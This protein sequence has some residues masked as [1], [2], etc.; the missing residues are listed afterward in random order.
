MPL[1]SKI[2]EIAA[3]TANRAVKQVSADLEPIVI[4]ERS[5]Q[6]RKTGK[7]YHRNMVLPGFQPSFIPQDTPR[8]PTWY[9]GFFNYLSDLVGFRSNIPL[10][11]LDIQRNSPYT[12]KN[13]VIIGVHGWFPGNIIRRVIG[14]PVGTSSKFAAMMGLATIQV[15]KERFG[16]HIPHHAITMISLDGEGKVADRLELLYSQ[17][18]DPSKN[19]IK[20]LQNADLLLFASHSQG[21]PVATLLCERLIDRN[22]INA[23]IQQT[24]ILAIAGISHG[25]YPDLKSSVIVKYVEGDPAKE[26]FDFNESTSSISVRYQST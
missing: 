8:K 11:L 17:L 7:K 4:P 15:F 12:T 14:E 19:W 16:I 24:G 21:T 6:N 25:P 23:A 2:S 18:S 20:K 10:P 22:I 26:L 3:K 1:F 9:I 5:E 13:I